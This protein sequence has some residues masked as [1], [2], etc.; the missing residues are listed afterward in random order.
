MHLLILRYLLPKRIAIEMKIEYKIVMV[1]RCFHGVKMVSFI[2]C[3]VALNSGLDS[4]IVK[5]SRS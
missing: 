3:G 2:F 4:L 1:M 5:V